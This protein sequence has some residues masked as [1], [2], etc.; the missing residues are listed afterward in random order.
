MARVRTYV[1]CTYRDWSFRILEGLQGLDG[2]RAG[3]IV[4]PASCVSSLAKFERRGIPILRV[5]DPASCFRRP[6]EA[7]ARIRGL[8]PNTIFHYGWSWMVPDE[9]LALCPNVTL[10]PGKLPRDR[11]GSPL[12]HLIRRGEPWTY[13]NII[14]LTQQTDA[15]PVYLRERMSL[16]GPV[17]AVWARMTTIGCQLTRNYLRRLER[18]RWR[19]RPQAK[20]PPSVARRVTPEQAE[21]RLDGGMTA[22]EMHNIIRA[23]SETDANTYVQPAYLAFGGRR[24]IIERSSLEAGSRNGRRGTIVIK[25]VS[26]LARLDLVA[27]SADVMKGKRA[28]A[29]EDRQGDRLYLTRLHIGLD[30]PAHGHRVRL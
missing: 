16:D 27:M 19:P 6:G 30:E 5:G 12:Q 22:V 2:W 10:H 1:W 14:R 18:G 15:G 24:L 25:R 23:Q 20:T 4:T 17:D 21:L 13:A 28:L 7:Y 11:G 8:R 26:D 29:V 3:L 9:L